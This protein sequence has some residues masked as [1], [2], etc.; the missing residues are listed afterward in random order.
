MKELGI[1]P[2]VTARAEHEVEAEEVKRLGTSNIVPSAQTIADAVADEIKPK[3]QLRLRLGST[4][5]L[6]HRISEELISSFG[7]FNLLLRK[8]R[9]HPKC[10]L[11]PLN[12]IPVVK[13]LRD[14]VHGAEFAR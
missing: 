4:E 6:G 14:E 11:Y 12:Q 8:N 1:K 2:T 3:R 9:A 10:S 7:L 13:R 5:R